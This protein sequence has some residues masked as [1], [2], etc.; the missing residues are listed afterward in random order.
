MKDAVLEKRFQKTFNIVFAGNIN[1]AQSFDTIL[2]A[3]D[4]VKNKVSK[5][6]KI[7][8]VGDGMSKK[9]L[10]N[11][12]IKLHLEKYF[13]FEG[14]K[15]V[16]E[17]P[18]YQNIADLMI[19]AL[20]KS[21]LFQYGIP[22]KVYSY[23]PSGKPIVG[24]MDGEGKKLIN[25]LASCG[26]CVKSGDSSGLADALVKLISMNETERAKIGKNGKDYYLKHFERERNLNR[27]IDFVINNKR[28]IDEEYADS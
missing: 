19:V 25:E 20:S 3:V 13:V 12:V 10:E 5:P 22:A 16:T 18:K 26:L 8:I 28:V 1:P 14:F 17:V 4:I 15:P 7:I 11:E 27:L 24:A 9:W 23:M 2:E 21:P 6:F